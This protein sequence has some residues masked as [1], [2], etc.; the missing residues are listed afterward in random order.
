VTVLGFL[1]VLSSSRSMQAQRA[2][3]S[4]KAETVKYIYTTPRDH[5]KLILR[6]LALISFPNTIMSTTYSWQSVSHDQ[7]FKKKK[8][9]K[10]KK[11]K[12]RERVENRGATT[13]W[14]HHQVI[15][16]EVENSLNSPTRLS[17]GPSQ[18]LR[19]CQQRCP[20][21]RAG[22]VILIMLMIVIYPSINAIPVE[23]VA[24]IPQLSDLILIPQLAQADSTCVTNSRHPLCDITESGQ[25]QTV[26]NL[27]RRRN[28]MRLL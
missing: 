7:L 10:L 27:L 25:D 6:L 3:N 2:H 21:Q 5:T 4:W 11:I 24:A 26:P 1:S 19:G 23:H 16:K 15:P 18:A 14:S 22:I 28:R 9:G 12:I 20:T 17:P 13:T 8:G